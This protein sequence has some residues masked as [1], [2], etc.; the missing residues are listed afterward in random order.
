[1]TTS[2]TYDLYSP[3]FRAHSHAV[4]HT[5]REHD[6]VTC[7]PGV[8][9]TTPIWFVTRY[10]DVARVLRDDQHFV[11]DPTTLWSPDELAA[12]VPT[13]APFHELA[14]NHMLNKDGA[15]HRRLRTLVQPA[16]APRVIAHWRDRIQAIA[17]ALL[18]RLPA[19]GSMDLVADYAFPL[20]IMVIAEL[21]GVPSAD[22]D[23][24][25]AWS[26]TFV[27][28]VV[29]AEAT[30]RFAAQMQAFTRY[31]QG[32]VAERRARPRADLLSALVAAEAE[33]DRLGEAELVSMVVLLIV[34]G[35]ETTVTLIGNSVLALLHHP[36]QL[37]WLQQEPA[38]V[39]P[40]VEEL[41]RYDS[42]VER[43]LPRF[44]AAAVEVGGQRME[45]GAQV[46]AVL[47]SANRDEAVFSAAD[48]LD[49]TRGPQRHLAFGTGVH[50]CLGAA[51]AR[52]EGE[53]A[54]R[55]LLARVPG[56]R[57]SGGAGEL[58]YRPVPRFH[59]LAALPVAWS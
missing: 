31:V 29:G 18:A 19:A 47:A 11:R 57:L 28:P 35:H 26:D 38:R 58:S 6:P 5:M 59:S 44:A 12:R 51:L 13:R 1:M 23:Q 53:I 9:G 22:R 15:D 27:S 4:Y 16:F 3:A 30:A 55:T 10:A 33:G 34:A 42:P 25:R 2:R 39:G 36:E 48:R 24:F 8:D 40:A 32:L 45:R 50:F 52:L 7:Q 46:V 54:L 14:D 56:L 41:L 17:D 43:A 20:P 21:L 49:V 37:R